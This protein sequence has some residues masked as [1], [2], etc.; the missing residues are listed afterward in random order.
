M[1]ETPVL[2]AFLAFRH[3][4]HR[5]TRQGEAISARAHAS[6]DQDVVCQQPPTH[7]IIRV[8][9]AEVSPFGWQEHTRR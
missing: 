6:G 3:I 1:Q 2:Q 8:K 4:K 5:L 9:L 7:N